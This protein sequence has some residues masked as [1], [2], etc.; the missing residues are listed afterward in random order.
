ML[1]FFFRFLVVVVIAVV[2][3][4]FLFLLA[5]ISVDDVVGFFLAIGVG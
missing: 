1:G 2:D 4:V 5:L 3:T